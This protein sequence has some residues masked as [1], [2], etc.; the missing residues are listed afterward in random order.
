MK[1]LLLPL[2]AAL[3]LPTAVSAESYWLTVAR[4]GAGVATIE[5]KDMEQCEEQG[6]IW[7]EKSKAM[8][9]KPVY[10]VCLKGK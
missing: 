9:R 7:V 5:M 4:K 10:Y 1:T 2:L 8:P 6:K 3:A